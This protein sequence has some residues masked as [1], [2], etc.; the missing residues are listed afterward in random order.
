MENFLHTGPPVPAGLGHVEGRGRERDGLP[1]QGPFPEAFHGALGP[2]G[3]EV[4]GALADDVPG[5]E[6]GELFHEGVPRPVSQVLIVPHDALGG[7]GHES[8]G[9]GVLNFRGEAG[10]GEGG[11]QRRVHGGGHQGR[12]P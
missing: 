7:V 9:E 5:A 6:L 1:L 4:G 12:P 3:E 11:S 2:G 10:G 8:G